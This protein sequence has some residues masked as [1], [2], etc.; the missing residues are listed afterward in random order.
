M[1]K[2]KNVSFG[3]GNQKIFEN[4]NF[5]LSAGEFAY[6]LGRTG[7]GKS[8]FFDLIY[9]N[10][11]P[12]NGIVEFEDYSSASIKQK[13]IPLL[14]RK[15]GMI[16]Q[17]FKLLSDRNVYSNLEFVLKV[18]GVKKKNIKKRIMLALGEVGLTDKQNKMPGEL[19][20]GEKQR[21]A[22]ARAVINEPRL[23]LADEPTGN[24][25]PKTSIEILD[26]LKKINRRG[27]A[28]IIATHD[29]DIVKNNLNEKIFKIENGKIFR[30]KL[31]IKKSENQ[32]F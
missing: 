4:L 30:V 26:L 28:V 16:F 22:I 6:L 9:M 11:F 18:T 7:I 17:D 20:G 27:T 1:L 24:L 32:K 29:Y 21:L 23:I 10:V 8:T 14:R 25:D 19:S 31:K 15:I 2:F 3:Y 13:E 12:T 5:K